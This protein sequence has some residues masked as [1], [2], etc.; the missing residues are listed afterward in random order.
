MSCRFNWRANTKHQRSPMPG[1]EVLNPVLLD[2]QLFLEGSR[3]KVAP[4]STPASSVSKSRSAN[5]WHQED[6]GGETN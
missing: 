4:V 3:S 5:G 2:I 1:K 6:G